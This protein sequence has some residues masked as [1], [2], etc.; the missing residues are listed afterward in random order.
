[1]VGG[2]VGTSKDTEE[3]V[4][5]LVKA[6]ADLISIDTAHGHS[7]KVMDIL[8]MIKKKYPN[9]QTVAGNVASP[10][11]VKD[12]IRKGADA[13]KVGMGPGSICTTRIIAGIGVPQVTA[14]YECSKAAKKYGIP[15]IADGGIKYSGD[16]TKAI[17]AGADCVMIGS[18][19]AGTDESPGETVFLEGR[20]FKIY[21][22][23]GSIAAMKRGSKDRYFQENIEQSKLVPEGV[24][25]RVPYRGSVGGC[26]LQ[27]IGGLKSGM[28][29]CGAKNIKEL[30][31][32]SEFIKITAAGLKE[33]HPHNIMIT[34]E[35]PN[36]WL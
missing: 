9:M 32:N 11:A 16:V 22:A 7:M 33:S 24:E 6:G 17:A 8:K 20:R 12:L 18:L 10:E 5:T 31:Q 14:V 19:F 21:D 13:V 29:Y 1:L 3:R 36:Y 25:A 28:G 35:P 2:A 34:S 4:D 15:I 27:L 26:V 30:Q 23:M